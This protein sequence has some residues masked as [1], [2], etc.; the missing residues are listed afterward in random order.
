[1]KSSKSMEVDGAETSRII[2]HTLPHYFIKAHYTTHTTRDRGSS[3]RETETTTTAKG[4]RSLNCCGGHA[5]VR[6]YVVPRRGDEEAKVL[7]SNKDVRKEAS[8]SAGHK[9]DFRIGP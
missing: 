5:H 8:V 1:M 2:I 4:N 6:S 7:F 9:L 3:S